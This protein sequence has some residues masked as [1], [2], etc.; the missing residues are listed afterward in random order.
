MIRNQRAIR[1]IRPLQQAIR[2]L[3]PAADHLTPLHPL[4]LQAALLSRCYY[5]GAELLADEITEIRPLDTSLTV[6]DFLLYCYYGGMVFIGLKRY[7]DAM[8]LLQLAITAPALSL[9]AII[10]EAYKKFALVALIA[11]GKVPQSRARAR[12]S[13]INRID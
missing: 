1:C 4:L 11:D 10:I 12:I 7:H 3:Q 9:S 13:S 5:V 8:R 2:M 6:T